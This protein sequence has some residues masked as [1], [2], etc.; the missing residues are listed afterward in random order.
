MAMLWGDPGLP[1]SWR[2]NPSTTA[3]GS[4]VDIAGD[5]V[6]YDFEHGACVFYT[7]PCKFKAR[8]FKGLP[9]L[10]DE[11]E[12]FSVFGAV[13]SDN[14]DIPSFCIDE[15][16]EVLLH[17]RLKLQDLYR[18]VELCSGMGVG[19]QG[20]QAVGLQTVVAV[21]ARQP[22]AQA[23]ADM[24]PNVSVV[25]GDICDDGTIIEV[26]QRYDR[27]PV[28]MAGFSCQP[29]SSGGQQRGVHDQRSETLPAV[30]RSIKMLRSPL[31]ILEC[32]KGAGSNRYV[33]NLLDT[34]TSE[35][36][37]VLS[38][39][40][41]RLEDCWVAKRERWWAILAAPCLGMIPI[42]PMP[43]L[44][45]PSKLKHVFSQPL[46]CGAE[47]LAQLLLS[48]E[49]MRELIHLVPHYHEMFLPMNGRCP[50]CL[51][52]LGSQFGPC[53][54][55]CRKAFHPNT[56]Q[57]RGVYGVFVP[58][59]SQ[60]EVDGVMVQQLRHP[61]PTERIGW[62]NGFLAPDSWPQPLRLALAGLG[63]M[64]S[65]MQA[66]WVGAQVVHF[67]GKLHFGASDVSGNGSLEKHMQQVL[68]QAKHVIGTL[69]QALFVDPY[70]DVEEEGV[71][72]PVPSP[73]QKPQ[74]APWLGFGHSGADDEVTLVDADSCVSVVCHLSSRS[75][76]LRDV[77]DAETALSTLLPVFPV[78][79]CSTSASVDLS[80]PVANR[81]LWLTFLRTENAMASSPG[82]EF[83]PISPTLPW[84]AHD[85]PADVAES[86]VAE[87]ASVVDEDDPLL[88]LRDHQ[89]VGVIP[90][91]IDGLATLDKLGEQVFLASTRATIL[92]NQAGK[93]SDDEITWHINR[94]I[95]ESG[96]KDWVLMPVL[97]ACECLKR[98][99][100]HL[101]SQWI[102]SLTGYPEVLV[103]A[104]AV[105][106]HWI[107]LMWRWT[108]AGLMVHSWDIAGNTP[109]CLNVL[110]D[111]LCKVVGART[112]LTHVDIRQFSTSDHCGL[113]TVR[114]IDHKLRGRM[115][116]TTTDEVHYLHGVARH[117]YAEYLS[118]QVV[119]PRPW[120]W[121]AGLDSKAHVRLHDLLLQH[122]VNPS[123][124]ESRMQLVCRTIGTF[125]VQDA[126]TSGNPWRSLKTLANQHKPPL[127]I[128]LAEELAAVV[129]ARSAK[130]DIPSRRRQGKAGGKG[131][132]ARPPLLDPCK[133]EVD[134]GAFVANDHPLAQLDLQHLGPLAEGIV[135]TTIH[136]IEAH[137]KVGRPISE[138]GLAALVLN[139]DDS[140]LSTSLEWSQV[141][142]VLRCKAN[143]QPVLVSAHL[144]QLG[145]VCVC[146][147]TVKPS[148]DMPTVDAA[149][150][151]IA[152]YRD[153]IEGS[154][155]DFT[156]SPIRYV[157]SALSPLIACQDCRGV[158]SP[159]C[160]KWHAPADSHVAEPILDIW[161]RQWTTATFK[162]CDPEHAAIFWVN[163]RYLL[164]RQEPVLRCS[165]FKGVFV[166]PRSLDGRTGLL[167]FQVLWLPREP[168]SEL[169][170]LQQ[171]HMI[172]QGIA[173]LGDRLGLRVAVDDAPALTRLVKPGTVYLSSGER[174]EYEAG[175]LPFGMDRLS[176]TRL[177]EAWK[178]QARPLHPVR[179]LALGTVW[180]LQSCQDPPDSVLKYQGGEIVI[181]KV[182]RRPVGPS[183]A[184]SPVVGA[185]DTMALCKLDTV[186]ESRAVDPW[187]KDDPWSNAVAKPVAPPHGAVIGT[188]L[189][190]LESKIEKNIMSRLAPDGDVDM[191][192]VASAVDARVSAL[193]TQVHSL[194]SK[195][196]QLEG[197]IDES[198]Q[199]SDAQ[200][201]QF[202]LQVAA[203]FEAQRSDMQ[204]LF[205]AQMG[206]IEAL[207]SKKARHE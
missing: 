126:M 10:D 195:Q 191:P 113:C 183:V 133:L 37:F 69:G 12:A 16:S 19:T 102:A 97:L 89:F 148:F 53:P 83:A 65:P 200:I 34:F 73:V 158:A 122:G 56:L 27:S 185:A 25:N 51:H 145:R 128:V 85:P 46:P 1:V 118:K 176:M 22:M 152:V 49:E 181:N 189:Q 91:I 107:P 144:I 190:Q 90:P 86:K 104:V 98:N 111:A 80:E 139:V 33:R 143:C 31:A 165:G 174:S 3:I 170:R 15:H 172:V 30:L 182:S 61:H 71:E 38:E 155:A 188:Q 204:G 57:E 184:P 58:L 67:I 24:H 74:H 121:A 124:V 75:T 36:H 41:L 50:T 127:K 141:R 179:S 138:N 88:L 135:V 48:T 160:V 110:H 142:S 146:P 175:P 78:I 92:G 101:I 9:E 164:E 149:C 14:I 157:L 167:S 87:E 150:I 156:S 116:P 2:F 137:L 197:K 114:W 105:N 52:S 26:Y 6:S 203:Q 192:P 82:V 63:Q 161:R 21:E 79:D 32:V 117:Q 11:V 54:C 163:V 76:T 178:W 147:A 60:V 23:F 18:I 173:R 194:V 125:E 45:Y 72:I 198:V 136:G 151:K 108:S 66:L 112:F 162:A 196:A 44:P 166:E 119:V 153:S 187:L 115:L 47:D 159:T 103:S 168:L 35:F 186:G 123:Q 40:V 99:G 39:G 109:R 154:W 28:I 95:R 207:L 171:C 7:W 106:G 43:V 64:A 94:M 177:C 59:D 206:Q 140:D 201:N 42:P 131:A 4:R 8:I 17:P 202:Q 84:P 180:L 134:F 62:A 199:R 93:W 77:I 129:K 120:I 55:G 96:K 5:L 205:T 13:F 100:V 20:L 193:E 29:Y 169:H 132:P 68:S 130:G 70:M 81:C